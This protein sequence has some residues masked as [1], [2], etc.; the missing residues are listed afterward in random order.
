[1]EVGL[2]PAVSNRIISTSLIT[3]VGVC[4]REWGE[5]KTPLLFPTDLWIH[6]AGFHWQRGFESQTGSLLKSLSP[7][8]DYK[9]FHMSNKWTIGWSL[10]IKAL[11]NQIQ[12]VAM[13]FSSVA[14]SW[15]GRKI[16]GL[17]IHVSSRDTRKERNKSP[18]QTY[19]QGNNA[20]QY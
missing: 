4:G 8:T 19:L 7:G 13:N 20:K 11:L 9:Y 10:L 12:M 16:H 14:I 6:E 15:N 1:M 5:D 17:A 3:G 18:S 2:C